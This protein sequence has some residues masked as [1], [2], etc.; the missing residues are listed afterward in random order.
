VKLFLVNVFGV[1]LNNKH[2]NIMLYPEG[3]YSLSK[4]YYEVSA[5]IENILKIFRVDAM[6][7][8]SY[9]DHENIEKFGFRVT[10]QVVF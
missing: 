2:Q 8:L 6:W 7:R 9:L 3:L 4:P 5:G 10:L 1:S